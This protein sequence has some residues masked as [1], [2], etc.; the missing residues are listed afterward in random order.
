M[1]TDVFLKADPATHDEGL[2]EEVVRRGEAYANAGASGLFA[3][4]L[5]D[6][7]LIRNL[8]DASR[9]PVNIL[10]LPGVPPTRTLAEFGVGR[11]S[12]GSQPYRRVCDVVKEAAHQ[13]FSDAS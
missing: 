13:A 4:G 7:N 1:R 8:C 12:Y 6:A 10:M 3:P 9:L 5:K 2:L 11:I